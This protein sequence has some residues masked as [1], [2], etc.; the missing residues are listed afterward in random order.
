MGIFVQEGEWRVKEYMSNIA[1]NQGLR[2]KLC[3]DV[4]ANK[5]PHA[6]VL[7]GAQGTGKHTV[8]LSC[9]AALACENKNDVNAPLPCGTCKSCKK[10]LE[11]K[12]PDVITVHREEGKATFGVDVVRG[13][14]QDVVTVPNDL[15]F[16]MYIV[17]EADKMTDEAQNALLL[18][19]EEPPRFV[20]FMLLCEN[21]DMLLETIRSRAPILR[22]SAL[23]AREVEKYLCEHDTRAAQMKLSA[24]RELSEIIM[25]AEGGIGRAI[26][27]L[28]P[29]SFAPQKE[30]R[31]LVTELVS[32][33]TE[34]A[35]PRK[36]FPALASFSNKRD[37]L[38]EQL[39]CLSM[40]VGDLVMLKKSDKAPL[41]FFADRGAAYEICD[42]S[43]LVFLY[44]FES[45]ILEAINSTARN[46]NVRLT[47]IKLACDAGLI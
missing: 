15:D 35:D 23:S 42:Q 41:C 40:A 10:I 26:E 1:G 14:R 34:G 31:R 28:E 30:I 39:R 27:Y 17:E 21:A 37:V 18:T 29:K 9:A 22:T 2:Q 8:A 11:G 45:A 38:T 3:R 46:A 33:A 4:L 13:L 36:I 43:S 24:P 12:S 32:I 20:R 5:F 25:A 7:E 44:G 16:K 6:Y 19:L 47:L